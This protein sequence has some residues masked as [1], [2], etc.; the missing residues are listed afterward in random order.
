MRERTSVKET[1]Y[2]EKHRIL[3]ALETLAAENWPQFKK[4]RKAYKK[5][6]NKKDGKGRDRYDRKS[7]LQDCEDRGLIQK[8]EH[9]LINDT[10]DPHVDDI[11][12]GMDEALRSVRKGDTLDCWIVYGAS[13]ENRVEHW[14]RKGRVEITIYT[15][16]KPIPI[17]AKGLGGRGMDPGFL[18][19]LK[20]H[21]DEIGGLL[22]GPRRSRRKKA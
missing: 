18:Q 19:R 10:W 1:A 9:G 11:L 13:A 16:P 7:L 3:Q 22:T 4:I 17:Q 15:P 20:S 12:A 2:A 21:H 8:D 14:R 5:F 6:R